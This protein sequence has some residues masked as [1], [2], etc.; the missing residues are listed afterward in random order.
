LIKAIKGLVHFRLQRHGPEDLDGH[1]HGHND[2]QPGKHVL[3]EAG[4]IPGLTRR[5]CVRGCRPGLHCI[6]HRFHG[7]FLL[8]VFSCQLHGTR[9]ICFNSDLIFVRR[10]VSFLFRLFRATCEIPADRRF[11][12]EEF[13]KLKSFVVCDR[14]KQRPWTAPQQGFWRR[15]LSEPWHRARQAV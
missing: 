13:R 5:F 1:D 4:R 15:L 14:R 7:L 8:F 10:A 9:P 3:T 2:D 6:N 12:S 11:V